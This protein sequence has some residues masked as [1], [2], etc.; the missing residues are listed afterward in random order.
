MER[1]GY[2]IAYEEA[3]RA[4]NSQQEI[5]K[6][7]GARTG[8][9]ASAGAIVLGLI[10][11]RVGLSPALIGA[12]VAFLGV[13]SATA[14]VLWPRRSWNFHFGATRV[15]MLYVDGAEPL[16]PDLMLRDLALHLDA[17]YRSNAK[18]INRISWAFAISIICLSLETLAAAY[19]VLGGG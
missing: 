15:H 16:S 19:H 8:L 1:T 6:T 11:S 17:N 12:T 13:T 14:Y 7:F 3:L 18:G 5:V 10:P 2:E 4:I 9:V